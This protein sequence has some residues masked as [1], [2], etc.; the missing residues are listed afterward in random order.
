MLLSI[1]TCALRDIYDDKTAL[2]MIREAGFDAYDYSM[3]R[4]T[5]E[6]DMLSDDYL[7]KA[8]ELREYA[9][10][11]GI[12]CR[13][14]HAP[15]DFEYTDEANI[16]NPRYLRLVRSM[17]VA[18]VLGAKNIVVHTV[19]YNLPE[20]FDLQSFSKEFYRSFIPYCEKFNINVSVENLVGRNYEKKTKFSV[21]SNPVEHIEFVKSLDSKWLN[22]CIDVGHSA[23]M[24][25]MPEDVISSMDNQLFKT[26]H[27]HDND[28]ENDS[29][30][31]PYEGKTDWEA[32]TRALAKVGYDGDFSFELEGLI[33]RLDPE[34]LPDGLKFA[35]ATG[36]L[37]IDKIKNARNELC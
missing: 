34:L 32:V 22:I 4:A 27:V 29:H 15:F 37:L 20:N 35:H 5:G 13:Q 28:F 12:A 30:V 6:K 14:A 17:E 26:I 24:G 8:K 31:L 2:K 25:Y 19:K 33:Y 9:D 7:E 10:K 1:D 36:R 3:F 18:S 16:S 11:I 23:I 21:F